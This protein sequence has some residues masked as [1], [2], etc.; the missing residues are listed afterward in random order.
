MSS[1]LDDALDN[2]QFDDIPDGEEETPK[3][4]R[5]PRSDKGQPRGTGTRRVTNKALIED[6]LIP[7][8]G[9]AQGLSFISPTGAAVLLSRGEASVTALVKIAS[10]NPAMLAALK[11]SSAIG[12][13]MELGTTL[14]HFLLAVMLDMGRMPVEHPMA[15][16]MGLSALYMEVHPDLSQNYNPTNGNP[17]NGFP[18]PFAPFVPAQGG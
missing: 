15:Q 12:P 14:L 6:L 7:Y 4:T 18:G 2:V 3:R 10:R 13:V 17:G 9:I 11:K 5:R 16:M 1:A 8:A